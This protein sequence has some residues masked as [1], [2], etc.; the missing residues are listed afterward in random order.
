MWWQWSKTIVKHPD[1][2]Y[3][4]RP[5]E[6]NTA[7]CAHYCWIDKGGRGELMIAGGLPPLPWFSYTLLVRRC[8]MSSRHHRPSMHDDHH[9][10]FLYFTPHVWWGWEVWIDVCFPFNS[11]NITNECCFGCWSFWCLLLP[12]LHQ[13]F[14]QLFNECIINEKFYCFNLNITVE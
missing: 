5:Q 4:Q 11:N 12:L 10:G 9:W 3:N 6:T 8:L 7:Y 1:K 13:S 14:R 2:H